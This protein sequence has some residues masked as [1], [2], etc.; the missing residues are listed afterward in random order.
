MEVVVIV[1]K[2]LNWGLRDV[3]VSIGVGLYGR[4]KDLIF[5][6]CFLVFDCMDV[7]IYMF[8]NML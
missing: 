7:Y 8:M 1:L 3:L 6:S 5:E 4:R 2:R